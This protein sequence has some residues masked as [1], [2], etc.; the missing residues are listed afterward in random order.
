MIPH[1]INK[2]KINIHTMELN[3]LKSNIKAINSQ[4]ILHQVQIK[5]K[6]KKRKKRK[7][8]NEIKEKIN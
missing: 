8:E 1:I 4:V 6:V 7:K 2:T 3:K 5:I